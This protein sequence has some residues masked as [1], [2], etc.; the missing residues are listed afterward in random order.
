MKK[1]RVLA[2]AAIFLLIAVSLALGASFVIKVG[3]RHTMGAAL[4]ADID[5]GHLKIYSGADPGVENAATGTLLVDWT[6]NATN[7]DT[8]GVITL[9]TV[10][11]VNASN[12]DTA[13]YFRITKSDGSTAV[14]DGSVGTSGESLNLNTLSI[15][16]GGPCSLSGTITVPAGS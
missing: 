15:V 2:L 12:T 14:A 13:G 1:S 3:E 8:D 10:A 16:S 7:T 5:S 11:N 9:G 4:A 6:L